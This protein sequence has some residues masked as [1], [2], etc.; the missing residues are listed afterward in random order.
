MI[1]SKQ[2]PRTSTVLSDNLP[3]VYA[4]SAHHVHL[5]APVNDS[6]EIIH[7]SFSRRELM[8]LLAEMDATK[9]SLESHY[10]TIIKDN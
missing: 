7:I 2:T 8:G 5:Q 4:T 1:I 9:A 3:D 6:K 10:N